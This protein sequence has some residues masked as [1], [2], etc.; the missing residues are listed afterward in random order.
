MD[1]GG[2][3]SHSQHHHVPRP[4]A[5]T[6][7]PEYQLPYAGGCDLGT[8]TVEPHMTAL[9]PFG[10]SRSS[11]TEGS[12]HASAAEGTGPERPDRRAHRARRHG[13]R[14]RACI[15]AARYDGV[16][17]IRNASPNYMVQ[18]LC[19]YLAEARCADPKASARPTHAGSRNAG[20]SWTDVDYAP[21]RGPDRGHEPH[22]RRHRHQLRTSRSAACRSSSWRSSSPCSSRWASA[23][24]ARP[25]Y[26]ARERPDPARRHHDVSVEAQGADRTRSTRCRSRA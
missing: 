3:S 2:R 26:T 4:A 24:S 10:L 22:R 17:V 12:Y 14:E 7:V 16:T 9:R 18:D 19:F 21:S 23:T 15:A 13:H 6:S 25:R 20:S 8:R 11:R 5:C 1:V